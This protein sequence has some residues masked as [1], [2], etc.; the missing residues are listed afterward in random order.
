MFSLSYIHGTMPQV[1]P[2]VTL[3][4]SNLLQS[5]KSS[6]FPKRGV[7]QTRSQRAESPLFLWDP[8]H[9]FKE[10]INSFKKAELTLWKWAQYVCHSVDGALLRKPL[11]PRVPT[12]ADAAASF[13][14]KMLDMKQDCYH[15]N[16][17]N[18]PNIHIPETQC[19]QNL[20]IF[21]SLQITLDQRKLFC[22]ACQL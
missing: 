17:S 4:A 9:I 22:N 13:C 14:E 2:H 6:I 11:I 12:S 16:N 19:K 15:F 1:H 3:A 20:P 8:L 7:L 21:L 5:W 10:F 18:L